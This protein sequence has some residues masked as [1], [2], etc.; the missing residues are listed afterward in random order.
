MSRFKFGAANRPR[1]AYCSR[2]GC[3]EDACTTVT[4]GGATYAVCRAHS[5]TND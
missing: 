3:Y 5:K 2:M 1:R 4:V